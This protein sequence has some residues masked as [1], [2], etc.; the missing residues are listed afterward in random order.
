MDLW[1]VLDRSEIVMEE[2]TKE[3]SIGGQQ[4]DLL[5]QLFESMANAP[6]DVEVA[7]SQ[8]FSFANIRRA[9]NGPCRIT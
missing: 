5:K 3:R 7:N 6:A 8:A 9:K 1:V 4:V 2:H